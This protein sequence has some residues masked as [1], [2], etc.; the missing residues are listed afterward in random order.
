ME[1][2]Y[3]P[4][5]QS[6]LSNWLAWSLLAVLIGLVYLTYTATGL[7]HRHS[8]NGVVIAHDHLDAGPHQHAPREPIPQDKS[9]PESESRDEEVYQGQ[10]AVP[11]LD[12]PGPGLE[13]APPDLAGA[14]STLEEFGP[15]ILR[16]PHSPPSRAPPSGALV[17]V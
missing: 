15:P 8:L 9:Q 3:A 1:T 4:R 10:T 12:D 2:R 6:K 17:V 11:L 5:S 14:S 16:G 7:S 13:V